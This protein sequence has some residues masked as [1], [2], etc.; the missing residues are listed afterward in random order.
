MKEEGYSRIF[1]STFLFGFVQ[2][3]R[4]LVGLIKNKVIAILLGPSGM[5]I[6]GIYNNAISLIKTGSSLGI[7][8]SAVKEISEAESSKS[9]KKISEVL[10]LVKKVVIF[11]S[12]IGCV[13]TIVFSPILSKWGFGDYSHTLQ[14]IFLSVVVALE[15]F[16]ENQLVILKGMR[17]LQALAKASLYGAIVGLVLGLPQ[18]YLY[19]ES[20]IVL[21][22]I[23]TS[24]ATAIVTHLFVRKIKHSKVKYSLKETIINAQPMVKMGVALMFSGFMSYFFNLITLGYI[25]SLGGLSDVGFYSAGST[26]IVSYFSMV[27]TSLNTDYYPR[28]AAINRDNHQLSIEIFKQSKVGLL[29]MFPIVVAFSLFSTLII[30]ILYSA[31]FESVVKYTDWAIIGILISVISNCYGYVF[32]VKQESKLYLLLS[33]SFNAVFL[34]NYVVMYRLFGLTGLGISYSLNV[35]IQLIVYSLLC[36]RRYNIKVDIKILVWAFLI[37]GS[38]LISY[39]L[40]NIEP[41]G[42]K[43]TLYAIYIAICCSLTVIIASKILNINIKN[44]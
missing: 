39:I 12:A 31:E 29:L 44:I 22:I 9:E 40:R 28:I 15:V 5:G 4:M 2:I 23:C 36:Y 7:N 34:V 3:V 20:G 35:L 19:G 32:I 33:I 10:S 6:I 38:I 41:F 25:Q 14:Y 30:E 17:Q 26:L 16:V 8:Q 1:K 21:S 11:T 43:L 42:L 18:I 37:T 27:T 13:V 24:I